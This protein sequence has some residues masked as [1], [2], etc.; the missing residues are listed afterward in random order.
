MIAEKSKMET[1]VATLQA[2]LDEERQR[3]D[4]LIKALESAQ[5]EVAERVRII[6]SGSLVVS[7]GLRPCQAP[8][9]VAFA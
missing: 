3:G 2:G 9:D 5:R 7:R 4:Q 1:Q 8:A 6:G